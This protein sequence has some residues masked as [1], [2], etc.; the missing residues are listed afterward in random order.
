MESVS[1]K[2]QKFSD[3]IFGIL[4]RDRTKELERSI[5]QMAKAVQRK[6]IAWTLHK[7]GQT[8]NHV[9][10]VSPSHANNLAVI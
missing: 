3:W 2:Q 5:A 8:C 4:D 7:A 10:E 1:S 9:E 6:T